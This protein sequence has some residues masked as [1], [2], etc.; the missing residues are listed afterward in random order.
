MV[1]ERRACLSCEY[2]EPCRA[3]ASPRQPSFNIGNHCEAAKSGD[4]HPQERKQ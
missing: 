2:G 1:I 3:T 4:S